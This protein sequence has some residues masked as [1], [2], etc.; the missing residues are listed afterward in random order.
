MTLVVDASAIAELLLGT[1]RGRRVAQAVSQED[2]VAPQHLTVEVVSVLRGWY[3]GGHIT[4]QEARQALQEFTLL[5]VRELPG[6]DLLDAVWDLRNNVS[7][8]DAMYVA[9]AQKL[10]CRLLSLDAR[11]IKAVPGTVIAP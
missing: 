10:E 9:L 3:L 8:Y 6:V 4:D 11:L 2:L 5:G 1:Q 7:V